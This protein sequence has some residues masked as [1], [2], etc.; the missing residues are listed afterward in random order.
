MKASR[1]S[2]TA[3]Q[4]A[5]SR[6]IEARR[7]DGERICFDPLAERF[8][9]ARYRLLLLGRPL[10]DATEKII[11]RLFPGHHHYVLVRT[12]Y[13]DEFLDQQLATHPSQLVILGAGY[14][15]RAYRFAERLADVRVFEV[16][17][18]ATSNA[19][20]AKVKAALGALPSHVTYVPVDF[21]RDTLS[22]Q[23]E[24]HGYRR[25]LRTVFLW[26]GTTPYVSAAGVDD[27]LRFIAGSSAP[28]SALIFDYVIRSVI[29][30]S[31]DL[32][33]ARS[34]YE[35]MKTTSE[36]FVFGIDEGQVE[37][38][39]MTRGFTDVKDAGAELARFLP[40]SRRARYVKPWW[41]IVRA[42][43]V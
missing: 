19:K 22:A 27:T 29:D 12:R 18:P 23:L 10:R 13:L 14:D 37:S 35:K 15:S 30:G 20:R 32:N 6:A 36:P 38:F 16:D 26:E 33:G 39:L 25:D 43:R 4:M 1:S 40:E 34:E 3:A 9:D 8:L 21:N 11:E 31:C 7:P 42:S 17:H 5:L 2:K 28:G 41:R 24:Q